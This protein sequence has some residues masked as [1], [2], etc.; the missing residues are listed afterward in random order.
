MKTTIEHSHAPVILLLDGK[1][2]L[3]NGPIKSWFRESRYSTC[4]A[5]DLLS[6]LEDL[7][8][9]TVRERPDVFLL[10]VD[11]LLD[12]LC[13]IKQFMQS[14]SAD[15]QIPIFAVAPNDKSKHDD[16]FVGSLQQVKDKLDSVIPMPSPRQT[17]ATA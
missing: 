9:F 4:E 3:V 17:T 5:H 11:S 7:S 1:A 13:S 8:D 2:N 16:C 10:E 15:S 6:I 12:D 14:T